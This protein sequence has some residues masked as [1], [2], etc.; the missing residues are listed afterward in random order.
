MIADAKRW[1]SCAWLREL[2]QQWHAARGYAEPTDFQRP[3]SR[4]WEE[5]LKVS[6]L[7]SAEARN[8][9]FRDARTLESG[10]LSNL[11]RNDTDR[12]KS[13]ALLS[14]L[15]RRSACANCSEMNCLTDPMQR[16]I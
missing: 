1:R 8:E 12:T 14:R 16:S 11:R 4:D 7:L 13:C 5:L 9:A 3:F 6:G 10:A 15:R 2:A